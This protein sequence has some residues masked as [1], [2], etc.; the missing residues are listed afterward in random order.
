[1]PRSHKGQIWQIQ[2]YSSY[3]I[4]FVSKSVFSSSALAGLC[5]TCSKRALLFLCLILA[6]FSS[7]GTFYAA[8]PVL[9]VNK[10]VLILLAQLR[11]HLSCEVSQLLS[12]VLCLPS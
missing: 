10:I 11:C 1:M 5:V 7:H 6:E 8:C 12:G 3:I 2:G 9:L 4:A